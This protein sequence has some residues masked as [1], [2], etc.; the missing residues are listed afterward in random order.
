MGVKSLTKARHT[1]Q[2]GRWILVSHCS[3]QFSQVSKM[4]SQNCVIQ[5][6]SAPPDNATGSLLIPRR[7]IG[8][9][10]VGALVN[11]YLS[12]CSITLLRHKK[13]H[14]CLHH[15]VL[16]SPETILFSS[17]TFICFTIFA[18]SPPINFVFA[19]HEL[20]HVVQHGVI[21]VVVTCMPS[22]P[23]LQTSLG[24]L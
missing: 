9:R 5:S 23:L 20:H 1:S 22:L 12:S 8:V 14:H 3:S 18:P 16:L 19:K 4:H 21:S 17:G 6:Y 15:T 24:Y 2:E 10:P 7:C 13:H 11:T